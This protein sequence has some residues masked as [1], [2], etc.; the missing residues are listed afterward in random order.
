MRFTFDESPVTGVQCVVI[1][2]VFSAHLDTWLAAMETHGSGRKTAS[3]T[4]RPT[5]SR[6]AFDRT[7]ILT[8]FIA[9]LAR[10][11]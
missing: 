7:L 1:F 8:L 4:D 10:A 11:T 6:A 3:Q 9:F 2:I 5:S